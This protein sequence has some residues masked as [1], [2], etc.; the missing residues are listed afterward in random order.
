VIGCPPG[1]Y[2]SVHPGF[3][4][5]EPP[6]ELALLPIRYTE[7]RAPVVP[8][9]QIVSE[10]CAEH[11]ELVPLQASVPED[12]VTAEGEYAAQ[13]AV[14]VKKDDQVGYIH[15]AVVFGDDSAD[16][17]EAPVFA[18]G[19]FEST[20]ILVRQ[21]AYTARLGLGYRKRRYLYTP[22]VGFFRVTQD[23]ATRFYP[24]TFP[25]ER[26]MLVVYPAVPKTMSPAALCASLVERHRRAGRVFE[27]DAPETPLTSD[28]GLHGLAYGLSAPAPD[29]AGQT[30]RRWLQDLLIF[31]D[32]HYLYLLSFESTQATDRA[33][34]ATLLS[35]VARSVRP[36]PAPPQHEQAQAPSKPPKDVSM[37][38]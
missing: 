15:I 25:R 30:G 20:A 1:F 9:R 35:K 22:P 26:G 8:L 21:L 5:F 18:E 17:I 3:V 27:P 12:F 34:F 23:L 4:F 24:P 38:W 31:A 7:K 28:F 29:V 2:K 36:L 14:L 13:T 33:A 32:A 11:D 19:A 16:V 10:Y 6:D 37:D